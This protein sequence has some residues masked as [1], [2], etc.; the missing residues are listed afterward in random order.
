MAHVLA[1]QEKSRV[2]HYVPLHPSVVNAVDEVLTHDFSEK[3]DAKPFFMYHSF[4]KWLLRQKMRDNDTTKTRYAQ[5]KAQLLGSGLVK[6]F[7]YGNYMTFYDGSTYTNPPREAYLAMEEPSLINSVYNT[8][9]FVNLGNTFVV[10]VDEA[11][12][13]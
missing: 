13:L 4:S 10:T 6:E 8:G 11:T 12:K 1:Q 2:E 7:D 3:D 9:V 5:Y